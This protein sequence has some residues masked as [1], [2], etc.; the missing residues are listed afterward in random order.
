MRNRVV[1]SFS[2]E[3]FDFSSVTIQNKYGKFNPTNNG[4]FHMGCE[5][6]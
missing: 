3:G 5:S 2:S 6:I 4:L 1:E